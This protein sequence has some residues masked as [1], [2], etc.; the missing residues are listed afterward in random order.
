MSRWLRSLAAVVLAATALIVPGGVAAAA[1][2]TVALTDAVDPATVTVTPGTTIEFVNGDADRHR[3][4]SVAGPTEFD[5]GNLDPGERFTVVLEVEGE[6]R[7]VDDRDRDDTAYHGTIVVAADAPPPDPGEPPSPPPI[8]GDVDIVDRTYRPAIITVAVGATVTWANNDDRP[9]T[10]T[11]R[12]RVWD[13]GIFDTGI[14]WS[15]SFNQAGTYD[16]FCTVHPDM[17]GTVLVTAGNE[18]PPPPAPTTTTTT[19]PPTDPPPPPGPTDVTII[20]FGYAPDTLSVPVGTTVTW[21]NAGDAPHTVTAYD[22]TFDSGFLAAGD[23]FERTFSTAGTFD[24]FCTLHP[25]M[26]GRIVV[27]AAPGDP[28]P[29]PPEPPPTTA[30]PPTSP[31]PGPRP[32]GISIVDNAFSPRSVT[33]TTGSTV[34]WT[35]V[36]SLPHTV[37][38]DDG[39]F[40]SGFLAT[41]AGYRR[42]FNQ[43]GTFSYLCTIH[44][45]MVGTITV[46]GTP[47]GPDSPPPDGPEPDAPSPPAPA[48]PSG[49]SIVDNDYD[50]ATLTVARG[51]EVTWVNEGQL[52]HTVTAD[53]G[54]FDSGFLLTGDRWSRTFD[55]V[56]TFSYLCT[57]H[58]EMIAEVVVVDEATAA[59]L[60][61]GGS[62]AADTA[63]VEDAAAAEPSST[64]GASAQPADTAVRPAR[65]GTD[66]P[67]ILVAVILAG[68]IVAAVI[69][70][71]VGMARFGRAAA[72]IE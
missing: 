55:E 63:A 20:D 52:P 13:S 16:Y 7:Y 1:T 29:P 36:G 14:S 6:Y 44:P 25:D 51:T 21:R 53:D 41:G 68:S 18:P 50:P 64:V 3:V 35:N 38:A 11:D 72:R 61:L 40:D 27:G 9:H 66:Q 12:N 71:T 43:P 45:E 39:R 19:P 31:P 15:R 8:S 58:P 37:T 47:T 17:V 23:R 33:V 60:G 56:G 69:A 10:V 70:F 42:T 67:G 48:G 62:A 57:I 26:V 22:A 59:S 28:P 54:G 65:S 46:S 34:T 4:R 5:S 24:Y 49:V 32:G 2:V 30:P